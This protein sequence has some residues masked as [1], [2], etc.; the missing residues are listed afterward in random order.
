MKNK[1]V[2][3][4]S[5]QEYTMVAVEDEAYVR[6]CASHVDAQLRQVQAGRLSQADAAV[7]TA[8]NVADQYF[9]EQEAAEHLRHQ[10]KDNLEE[11]KRLN[12]E[13][14]EAKREIFR[15]QNRKP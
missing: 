14:S 12:A 3:T 11:V 10:I 9:R 6:K 5:G 4:I 1:V 8:M 15:L 13:L 2:V 7:L